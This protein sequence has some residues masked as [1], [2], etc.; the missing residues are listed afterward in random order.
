MI[1]I[2]FPFFNNRIPQSAAI[3]SLDTGQ[4][5]IIQKGKSWRRSIDNNIA[6]IAKII[7]TRN[8]RIVS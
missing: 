1:V 8:R 3:L 2:I 7:W 6:R 4:G 5:H